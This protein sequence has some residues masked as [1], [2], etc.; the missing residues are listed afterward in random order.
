MSARAVTLLDLIRHQSAV[1]GLDAIAC[2][3]RDLLPR[4]SSAGVLEALE[5]LGQVPA[6]QRLGFIQRRWVAIGWRA[7]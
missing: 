7:R 6:A 2:V 4:M 5:A 3:A 1:G